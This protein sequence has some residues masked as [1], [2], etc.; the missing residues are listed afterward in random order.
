MKM[1]KNYLKFV[2]AAKTCLLAVSC[3]LASSALADIESNLHLHYTFDGLTAESS[4]VPDVSGNNNAGTR[5]GGAYFVEGKFGDALHLETVD[6][7]V[8]KFRM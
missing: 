6:D 2:T 7:Y 4:I 3:M 5:M 1:K 8:L